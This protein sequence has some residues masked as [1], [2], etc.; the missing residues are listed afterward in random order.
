MRTTNTKK[1]DKLIDAVLNRETNDATR[2]EL[3]SMKKKSLLTNGDFITLFAITAR[4]A[5]NWR[6]GRVI[7][8]FKIYRKI[9]YRWSSVVTLLESKLDDPTFRK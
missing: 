3:E 6:K 2:R 5:Y 4:T 9:Y 8:F 1:L 7:G